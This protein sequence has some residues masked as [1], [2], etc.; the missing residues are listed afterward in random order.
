MEKKEKEFSVDDLIPSEEAA[1]GMHVPVGETMFS[2]PNKADDEEVEDD[3]MKKEALGLTNPPQ[4][5]TGGEVLELPG[6]PQPPGMSRELGED[7]ETEFFGAKEDGVD[8]P[9]EHYKT[10]KKQEVKSDEPD[11]DFFE[12]LFTNKDFKREAFAIED[13][14]MKDLLTTLAKGLEKIGEEDSARKVFEKVSEERPELTAARSALGDALTKF[15]R[16]IKVGAYVDLS[17]KEHMTDNN[18][19]LDMRERY[20]KGFQDE[21]YKRVYDGIRSEASVSDVENLSID[22]RELVKTH[23]SSKLGSGYVKLQD[24]NVK[25]LSDKVE[26][27]SKAYNQTVSEYGES[28]QNHVELV[29]PYSEYK[30]EPGYGVKKPEGGEGEAPTGGKS[31]TGWE[32]YIQRAAPGVGESVRDA[33]AAYVAANPEKGYDESFGSWLAWYN[34]VRGDRHLSPDEV[35]GMLKVEGTVPGEEGATPGEEG[36]DGPVAKPAE[37]EVD[38]HGKP[39][40]EDAEAPIA[41]EGK[42]PREAL[43]EYFRALSSDLREAVVAGPLRIRNARVRR[44]IRRLGGPEA[45]AE[46]VLNFRGGGDTEKGLSLYGGYSQKQGE[47]ETTERA[48]RTVSTHTMSE[49]QQKAVSDLLTLDLKDYREKR[50]RGGRRRRRALDER[51]EQLQKIAGES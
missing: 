3:D 18:N 32:G 10:Q 27:A 50:Q 49:L 20:Y 44:R 33:W 22:L 21:V 34:S 38:E 26:E 8:F 45:A 25:L 40:G 31:A 43:E 4:S 35:L 19:P 42:E 23:L 17:N 29:D 1:S 47:G 37:G 41:E 51:Y 46:A 9:P 15:L 5:I 7:E 30:R 16:Y 2:I 48:G 11:E 6:S 14:K 28:Y 24:S 36:I 13:S 39:V 12:F